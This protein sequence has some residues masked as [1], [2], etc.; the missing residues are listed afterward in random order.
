[1]IKQRIR[2]LLS[3]AEQHVETH[4]AQITVVLSVLMAFSALMIMFYQVVVGV[5]PILLILSVTLALIL[6][7][8]K[9][10]EKSKKNEIPPSS[11]S[12]NNYGQFEQTNNHKVIRNVTVKDI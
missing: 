11:N 2:Y 3:K 4:V 10:L 8:N 1:M 5:L 6:K 7:V 12:E 9:L